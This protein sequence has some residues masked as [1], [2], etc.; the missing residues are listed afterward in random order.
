[1]LKNDSLKE[2]IKE[3][4]WKAALRNHLNGDEMR[5]LM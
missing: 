2:E 4:N 5:T 1:M 3:E